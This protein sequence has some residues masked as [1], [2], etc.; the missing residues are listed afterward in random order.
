MATL[1]IKDRSLSCPYCGSPL[2]VVLDISEIEHDLYED[3][4]ICCRPILFSI[5]MDWR[6]Q[7]PIISIKREDD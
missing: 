2:E 6:D 7:R 1:F 3:C 5:K 4:E